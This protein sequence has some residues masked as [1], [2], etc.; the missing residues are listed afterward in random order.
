MYASIILASV[1]TT[2][3]I[4]TNSHPLW[5]IS[6]WVWRILSYPINLG[7]EFYPYEMVIALSAVFFALE[8]VTAGL[9][10]ILRSKIKSGNRG[11]QKYK[12]V[13][14][15][16]LL[17]Q[18]VMGPFIVWVHSLPLAGRYNTLNVENG[19]QLDFFT[20][21]LMNSTISIAFLCIGAVGIIFSLVFS[22]IGVYILLDTLPPK[23]TISVF[24]CARLYPVLFL[25]T[26]NLISVAASVVCTTQFVLI[27]AA[28]KI[29][30]GLVVFAGFF[31]GLPFFRPWENSLYS[32]VSFAKV[33]ASIVPLVGYFVVDKTNADIN[34][35]ILTA[36]CATAMILGLVIGFVTV[37]VYIHLLRKRVRYEL[38]ECY[39]DTQGLHTAAQT[40]FSYLEEIR[41]VRSL[42]LFIRFASSSMDDSEY[43][44]TN[45]GMFFIKACN[46][47][48]TNSDVLLESAILIMTRLEDSNT[49]IFASTVLYIAS[50]HDP[51]LVTRFHLALRNK[52]VEALQNS[53]GSKIECYKAMEVLEKKQL[54]LRYHIKSFFKEL[55]L[56]KP[57][58]GK[59]EDINRMI[60]SM[61]QE[62]DIKFKN[63]VLSNRNF[64]PGLLAY[65]QYLDNIKFEKELAEE[66][67]MDAEEDEEET[68]SQRVR[69]LAQTTGSQHNNS[70]SKINSSFSSSKGHSLA[71]IGKRLSVSQLP[72]SP[73]QQQPSQDY[74]EEPVH[75]TDG[76]DSISSVG[77]DLVKKEA[78]YRANINTP[79]EYKLYK[80]SLFTFFLIS[81]ITVVALFV[82]S[83]IFVSQFSDIISL[84]QDVC[85]LS[86]IPYLLVTQARVVQSAL[87]IDPYD[88]MVRGVVNEAKYQTSYLLN[89]V[90]TVIDAAESNTLLPN[91]VKAYSEVKWP[92]KIPTIQFNDN[93]SPAYVETNVSISYFTSMIEVQ[94]EKLLK[95]FDDL[96]Q[97][98][99]TVSNFAFLSLYLNRLEMMTSFNDFC[100]HFIDQSEVTTWNDTETFFI[101][102]GC[103]FGAYVVISCIYLAIIYNHTKL[104][105]I[106]LENIFNRIPKDETGKIFHSLAD[107]GKQVFKLKK[108]VIKPYSQILASSVVM[109]LIVAIVVAMIVMEFYQNQDAISI[110]MHTTRSLNSVVRSSMRV[111]FR[112]NEMIMKSKLF[113]VP[114]KQIR[115]E[116]VLDI[117]TTTTEW[118]SISI[119]GE[120]SG[121][122]S[123]IYGIL[124]DIDQI[125]QGTCNFSIHNTTILSN[126]T[127]KYD[128]MGINY[129]VKVLANA[130][131][132]MNEGNY[133]GIYSKHE[134][135][136]L[137]FDKVYHISQVF[138][139]KVFSFIDT[140]IETEKKP[141][142]SVSTSFFVIGILLVLVFSY[143]TM[144]GVSKFWSENHSL[145]TMLN[146]LS[147]ELIENRGFLMEYIVN[148][149]II[150]QKPP[151]MQQIRSKFK[152][153]RVG[154]DDA[155]TN[156]DAMSMT[157]SI[158]NAGVDGCIIC[159]GE[160]QII[161]FNKAAE[162]L[163]SCKKADVIGLIF[164]SFFST[165]DQDKIGK[166]LAAIDTTTNN[167]F[168]DVI[169]ATCV[170]RNKTTFTAKVS[171]SI[172]YFMSKP[173]ISYFIRDNSS[174]KKQN[175]LINEEKRKSEELLLNI[176]PLPMANRLKQGEKNI[177]EK[178]NDV[179]VFFSDSKYFLRV[180][181]ITVK[182]VSIFDLIALTPG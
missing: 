147:W 28:V 19:P 9:L 60:C 65:A 121:Y 145:R 25:V 182:S 152:K 161:I 4:E 143:S 31:Y 179:S 50:K 112:L 174:E 107:I 5:G 104:Q 165:E 108:A 115:D 39:K 86:S 127:E 59:L 157:K 55:L 21:I 136:E 171:L 74:S 103:V 14:H 160:G 97:V 72:Q 173:I 40:L 141:K 111:S 101:V 180:Y 92:A 58:V 23:N 126:E 30:L 181:F 95:Q 7:I 43:S 63:L 32:G 164:D 96:Q 175:A 29:V 137:Y 75:D 27:S 123:S 22:G 135:L 69:R 3:D 99:T 1:V 77:G 162:D 150:I 37:H 153:N 134:A 176:L 88:H 125:L 119:G 166:M 131:S 142:L 110:T 177:S 124:P 102:C 79:P 18:L 85:S 113:D 132:E 83:I 167:S 109:L 98:N 45:L 105:N 41:L 114:L 93:A 36:S 148:H 46:K 51:S 24:S 66:F 42:T 35:G 48:I 81:L 116:N 15:I 34:G 56:E 70:R 44:D 170:R 139:R 54:A 67:Y 26:S 49:T 146:Y 61:I 73:Q 129:L 154:I 155:I 2:D 120:K 13:A 138:A 8:L 151:L 57:D 156:D 80:F 12:T 130:Y 168:S 117:T 94:G 87:A 118:D 33:L 133:L 47:K 53:R 178:I 106:I 52:E 169:E 172:S 82:V 100:V 163:F 38:H 91:V 64:K 62:C 90:Q 71:S 158:L 11:V 6:R 159:N 122:T 149:N 144:E 78:L 68:K 16:I 84:Q 89:I 140:L 76:F 10:F 17:L 128:C 20:N